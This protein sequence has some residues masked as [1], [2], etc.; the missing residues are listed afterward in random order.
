M[1]EN[2]P[3]PWDGGDVGVQVDFD[4]REFVH[5]SKPNVVVIQTSLDQL[6]KEKINK[7]VHI[8]EQ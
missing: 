7:E 3:V 5:R 6:L 8:N 2:I 1:S 4:G